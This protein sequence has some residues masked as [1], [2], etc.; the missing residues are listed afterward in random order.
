M[1][2]NLR[3]NDFSLYLQISHSTSSTEIILGDKPSLPLLML[4]V[5]FLHIIPVQVLVVLKV[6][7][8]LSFVC[9]SSLLLMPVLVGV[10]AL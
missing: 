8:S 6:V 1:A 4:A 2:S 7:F 3:F 10:V 5:L 9:S